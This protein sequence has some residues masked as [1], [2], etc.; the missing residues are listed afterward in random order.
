MKFIYILGLEHSGTTIA[1]HLLS[2][3]K[4]VLGLGEVNS[5]FN[6]THMRQYDKKWGNLDDAYLCSCGLSWADCE[7]W[8]GLEP[9]SGLKSEISVVEKYKFLFDKIRSEFDT[10]TAIVDSSKSLETLRKILDASDYLGL[11]HSNVNILFC[12]K[13]VRSFSASMSKKNGQSNSF[14]ASYRSFNYWHSVNQSILS[15]LRTTKI[16]YSINLYEDF[17]KAPTEKIQ[18]HLKT[19]EIDP[20]SPI[21]VSHSNSHIAMGNKSFLMRNRD[22]IIYDSSWYLDDFI[23]LSYL[24]NFKARSLN[25][26]LYEKSEKRN[27]K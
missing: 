13:D 19:F 15:F 8:K 16:P 27:A 7:F 20:T 14:L 3:Q 22:K 18:Q 23:H 26:Q 6:S 2:S 24:T 11:D 1:E 9:Y 12:A 21:E 25:K 10:T 4:S 5:F 17:C